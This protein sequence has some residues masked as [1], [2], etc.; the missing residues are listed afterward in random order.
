MIESGV[1]D[2]KTIIAEMRNV[3]R[4]VPSIQIEYVSIVEAETMEAVEHI[5]G[6]VLAAVAARIGSTRL[7][8]NIVVDCGKE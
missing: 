8:D 3:L 7:I 1:R 5:R 2:S 4:T 6:R